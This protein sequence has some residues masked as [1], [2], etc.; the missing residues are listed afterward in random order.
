MQQPEGFIQRGIENKVCKLNK[1]LSGLKQAQRAWFHK[2]KQGLLGFNFVP[3]QSNNSL[4]TKNYNGHTKLVFEYVNDIIII[5]SS[6]IKHLM[7]YLA[8]IFPSRFWV[9][10]LTFLEFKFNRSVV[11]FFYHNKSISMIYLIKASIDK[12]KYIPTSMVSNTQLYA[13]KRS[14]HQNPQQ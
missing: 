9:P 4:Y 1:S 12:F 8:L 10:V 2:L 11:V 6:D 3:F 14:F 13:H 7:P 5:G